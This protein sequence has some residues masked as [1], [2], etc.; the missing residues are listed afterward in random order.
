MEQEKMCS[1]TSKKQGQKKFGRYRRKILESLKNGIL[2]PE[3]KFGT[4]EG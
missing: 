4:P 1:A 3:W 2:L